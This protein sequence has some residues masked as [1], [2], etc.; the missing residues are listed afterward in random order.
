M[1]EGSV[2]WLGGLDVVV[3]VVGGQVAFVPA[4]RLH[5]MADQDWDTVYKPT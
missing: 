4:V 1:V 5:E 2:A 3:T